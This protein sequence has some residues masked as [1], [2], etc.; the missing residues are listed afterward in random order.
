MNGY[1]V[2]LTILKKLRNVDIEAQIAIV[3]TTYS[4]A[5]EVYVANIH[6]S[7]EVKE[8]ATSLHVG[9]WSIGL[10]IPAVAHFLEATSR[11]AR[12]EV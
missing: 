3:G 1:G 2:S 10:H 5:V 4:L 7:L 6:D 9:S 8:Y 11:K 12:F